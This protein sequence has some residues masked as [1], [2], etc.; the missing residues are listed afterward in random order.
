[1]PSNSIKFFPSDFEAFQIKSSDGIMINGV[2]GGSG[3][4]MLLLHGAPCNLVNWRK[5]APELAKNYT[6]IATDLRG[7]GESDMPDGGENH[8]NYSKR[9]MAQD[10]VDVMEHWGFEKFHVVA[11][12]RGAR[13]AH[14]M[15]RDHQDKVLTL[16]LM[17]IIPTLH[18]Y[19]NV[20][21]KFGEAYWFWFFYTVDAPVPE[22]FIA[23]SDECFMNI[24]FFGK[25]K[26]MIDDDAFDHFLTTLKREGSAHAQCEDYR[27]ASTI[28][29]EH[30]KAD[31][32][33]KVKCPTLVLWGDENPLNKGVDLVS[34]WKERIENVRGH[35]CPS[36]HW[37][38]EQIPDQVIK[39]VREFIA[40]ES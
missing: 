39:E 33:N 14:R 8:I 40:S 4:P 18:L 6:I 31:L 10:Q 34:L 24:A 32:D 36:A 9:A 3:P 1:M 20:D 29:L 23:N 13:V 25:R 28:D 15:A 35:G 37:L 17:D 19:G 2:K 22:T 12:D 27:A 7:Y 16:T 26:Q 5:V 21:R 11:H 30:D 38:P